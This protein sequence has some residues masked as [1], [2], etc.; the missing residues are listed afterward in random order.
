MS[1][2]AVVAICSHGDVQVRID[3]E[4]MTLEPLV[5]TIPEDMEIVILYVVP[6]AAPNLLP[7]AMKPFV[8][9]IIR[10]TSSFNSDS[11][12]EDMKEIV[13]SI[14]DELVEID[15]LPKLVA[16]EVYAKNTEYSEDEEV[17]AYFRKPDMLYSML[18][19]DSGISPLNKE[20]LRENSTVTTS[21]D[22]KYDWR[23]N[24]LQK[25]GESIDLMAILNPNVSS[26]RNTDIR[27]EFSITSMQALINYLYKNGV[28]KTILFDFSCSVIRRKKYAVTPRE[29]RL[30]AYNEGRRRLRPI[31]EFAGEVG[32]TS[33][34]APKKA[35]RKAKGKSEKEGGRRKKHTRRYRTKKIY[36]Y[37]K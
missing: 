14:K 16:A 17:L 28:R 25:G 29:E 32:T 3:S 12:I 27:D 37:Y 33:E 1:D 4:T 11:S 26:L 2:T 23:I 15:E 21:G 24:L 31:I 10:G 18:S 30:I 35:K 7:P 19:S 34:A 36:R 6:T 9:T 13:A 8:D 5:C 22:K 20:L